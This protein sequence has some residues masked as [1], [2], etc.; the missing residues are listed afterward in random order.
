MRV[1]LDHALKNSDD[2]YIQRRQLAIS[3][4][5]CPERDDLTYVNE[6]KDP[7]RVYDKIRTLHYTTVNT[8]TKQILVMVPLTL[9]HLEQFASVFEASLGGRVST[10]TFWGILTLAIM[11]AG[12][13]SNAL[14]RITVPA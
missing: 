3:C 11:I 2:F 1:L 12:R 10:S 9:A 5:G 7:Q 13:L 8:V 14:H 4:R 6:V